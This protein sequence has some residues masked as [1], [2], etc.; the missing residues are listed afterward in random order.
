MR[1]GTQIGIDIAWGF[2]LWV[3]GFALGMLF[4]SFIPTQYLGLAI[5]PIYLAA[6]VWVCVRQFRGK[7]DSVLYLL[8]VGATWLLIAF[9]LDYIFIV[10]AFFVENYYDYDVL[11]Y[12]LITLLLPLIVGRWNAKATR[13]V[14]S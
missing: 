9:T 12:Y 4:F 2:G 10:Q 14:F 8:A 1:S 7:N 13:Q 11:F 3:F 5:M 6:A